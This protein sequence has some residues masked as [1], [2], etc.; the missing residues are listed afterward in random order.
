LLVRCAH[1]AE[2]EKKIVVSNAGHIAREFKLRAGGAQAGFQRGG[3]VTT[4]ECVLTCR[5]ESRRY[6]SP[7]KED[8]AQFVVPWMPADALSDATWKS[9]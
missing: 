4:Q 9:A 6:I 2:R 1:T 5:L 7:D 8:L 3:P